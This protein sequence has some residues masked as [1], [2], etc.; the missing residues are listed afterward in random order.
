AFLYRAFETRDR[1]SLYP[2]LG[3]IAAWL[4]SFALYYFGIL[5]QDVDSS[6]LQDYHTPFFY[7]LLPMTTEALGQAGHLWA[8]IFHTYWGHTGITYLIGIPALLLGLMHL[9]KADFS[10]LLVLAFPIIACFIASGLKQY[11]MLLRLCLFF[12]PL[13]LLLSG[14]GLAQLTRLNVA[15]VRWGSLGLLLLTAS[16]HDRYRHFVEPF[17]IED[18]RSALE[19][20]EAHWQADDRLL[21]GKWAI[22]PYAYYSS[23]YPLVSSVLGDT[24]TGPVHR[25][26]DASR[27]GRRVWL[28]YTHLVAPS[29]NAVVQ[30]DLQQLSEQGLYVEKIAVFEATAIYR[31]R[32]K[33]SLE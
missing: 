6:Y 25:L 5:K 3:V 12:L 33:E 31:V 4:L 19:F 13:L 8:S 7:P 23:H 24:L 20:V 17:Q 11:S 21:L 18:P 10:R 16:L 27:T 9:Y 15:V 22:P 2:W 30:R 26:R 14:I 32:L 1:R 29:E 28:I